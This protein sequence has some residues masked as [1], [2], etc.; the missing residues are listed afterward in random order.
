MEDINDFNKEQLMV[1][2]NLRCI[3]TKPTHRRSILDVI[4]TDA[5][6]YTQTTLHPLIGLCI[7]ECVLC[8][9]APPPRPSYS[10]RDYRPLRD[11]SMRE[12]GQ[13]VTGEGWENIMRMEDANDAADS[14]ETL[15]SARYEQGIPTK[16]YPRAI[17]QQTVDNSK[18]S[19]NDAPSSR[20]A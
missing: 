15:L 14:L 3:V 16:T 5:E 20:V 11:S 1:D 10:I 6:F 18:Y 9:P 8:R 4:L 7:H 12:F 19:G 13:W 17:R 2:T